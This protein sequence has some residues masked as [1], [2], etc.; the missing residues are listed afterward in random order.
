M[1]ARIGRVV[2]GPGKAYGEL[3]R[4]SKPQQPSDH[5]SICNA[6]HPGTLSHLADTMAVHR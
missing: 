6:A 4:S 5:E 2:A 1:G 3:R